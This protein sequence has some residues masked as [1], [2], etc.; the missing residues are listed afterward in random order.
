MI[1]EAINDRPLVVSPSKS[2]CALVKSEV[3]SVS[4]NGSP[5]NETNQYFQTH[6]IKHNPKRISSPLHETIA[7]Q[8][9]THISFC[10]TA[11]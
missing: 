9:Q 3:T 5:V 2:E 1:I 6:W 4:A 8:F 11:A 10:K 7:C